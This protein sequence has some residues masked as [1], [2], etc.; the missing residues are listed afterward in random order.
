MFETLMASKESQLSAA[1]DALSGGEAE[2]AARF[3]S[4]EEAQGEVDTLTTQVA[5]D[6]KFINEAE[7]SY[8]IKVS[9]WKERKR[10]QTGEVA[11][12]SKAISVLTSDEARDLMSSSFKSQSMLLLDAQDSSVMQRRAARAAST[13]RDLAVKHNDMR[14]AAFAVSVKFGATTRGHFDNVVSSIDKMLSDLNAEF[15][16]DLKTKETCERDRM[17]NSKKAKVTSQR[18]DDQFALITRQQAAIEEKHK[19][20]DGI[21]AHVKELKLQMKEAQVMRNKERAEYQTAKHVDEEA[22]QTI[23]RSADVLAK[24]YEEERLSFVSTEVKVLVVSRESPGGEAPAPPPSTWSKPYG[25][26]PEE[27]NGIQS[28]M[29]MVKDDIKKDIRAAK[30]EEDKAQNDFA[31]FNSETEGMISSLENERVN[32]EGEIGDAEDK[33]ATATKARIEKKAL[34]DQTLT[35]LSSIAPGCDFMAVNFDLRKANRH[36]EIDGL[37]EAKAALQGGSF[38]L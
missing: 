4:M 16:E 32:L 24:F 15:E 20:V 29:K 9:E 8:A 6:V 13:L 23:Q 3:T 10:L 11:A 21:V 35:L 28:I 2:G 37:F 34:L 5:N 1:Q 12:L 38:K 33:I 14:L 25:G 22:A 26:A 18:M 17:E 27:S 19:E 31:T 36:A 7:D 30:T